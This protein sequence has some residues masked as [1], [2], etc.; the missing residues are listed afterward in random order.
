MPPPDGGGPEKLFCISG[1]LPQLPA[2]H[3]PPALIPRLPM[4]PVK[5]TISSAHPAHARIMF[6]I[7]LILRILSLLCL[8][9]ETLSHRDPYARGETFS[10]FVFFAIHRF[11]VRFH[12]VLSLAITGHCP[13]SVSRSSCTGGNPEWNPGS[14][15]PDT[16]MTASCYHDEN[17]P[18]F[19]R[20]FSVHHAAN[21][22]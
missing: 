2:P 19:A 14:H 5:H 6:R 16:P 9:K 18:D 3:P 13:V 11:L 17:R 15:P 1:E 21:I 10:E 7:N 12:C 4:Q 8:H 22:P 20:I